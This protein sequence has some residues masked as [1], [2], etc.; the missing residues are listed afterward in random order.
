MANIVNLNNFIDP[1]LNTSDVLHSNGYAEAAASGVMGAGAGGVSIERR[2]ELMNK[3][4]TVGSYMHSRL[5]LQGSSVKA[6]TADQKGGR[7]Y[8]ASTGKFS[9]RAG[10]ANRR[11]GGVAVNK[12]DASVAKREH[13]IEPPTRTHDPFA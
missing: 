1:D 6:R 2:R 11:G 8:D 5:G 10:F 13:F 12:I 4:R 3:P 7:V 9:D